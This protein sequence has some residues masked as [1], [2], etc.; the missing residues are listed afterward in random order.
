[1]GDALVQAMDWAGV[2]TSAALARLLTAPV[3]ANLVVTNVP[4][5]QRR[6]FLL[7]SELAESFPLVP[8]AAGQGLGIAL[9]S[10][11][12]VMHW[13]FNA[14]RDLLPDLEQFVRAVDVELEQL[15]RA[16]APIQAVAPKA[17]SDG[18][19]QGKE[20][21]QRPQSAPASAGTDRASG[22]ASRARARRK[23]SGASA[24][25]LACTDSL[26]VGVSAGQSTRS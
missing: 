21:A 11:N 2:Q 13:G 26:G 4:G 3:P 22:R 5:P 12:G 20:D 24:S 17:G 10:Y 25:D 14:D 7:E 18:R 9:Y 15:H 6:Q 16:H 23:K 1:M 8:L 19:P